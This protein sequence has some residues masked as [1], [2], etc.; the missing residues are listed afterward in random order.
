MA[1]SNQPG[2]S[3]PNASLAAR[4]RQRFGSD[5]DPRVEL[6]PD[7]NTEK[8]DER[9]SASVVNRLETRGP[10]ATR[11]R[12][13]GE[14]ARGGMG[15]IIEVFDE[16]LRRRLAM[17]VILPRGRD[18]ASAGTEDK[19]V[20]PVLLARFL[21]EAQVTGQLDHPG[22]VPV[23]ELGLD[24]QG[25]VFFTMR[26]VHGRDLEAIFDLA[27]QGRE[28]WSTTRALGVLQKVCEAMAYAHEKGVVHRDLKPANVM[29]G[30]FGEVYVMDWGLARVR[31]HVDRHD[32]RPRAT[33]GEA[34]AT[35]RP[36]EASNFVET[37]RHAASKG[38][39]DE[40]LYTMDGDI[41][42]TP[43]YMAPEQARGELDKLDE[44]TDVYAVGA[45]LYRLLAGTAPYMARGEKV[46][47]LEIWKRVMAGPPAALAT[48][49]PDAPHE[50]AAICNKAMT[51]DPAQRYPD[52]LALSADL[53]AFLEGRVVRAF[54]TGAWAE[55]RKWLGR[56]RPLAAALAAGVVALIGGLVVSLV[57]ADRARSN[58]VLA[59][60]RRVESDA[61]AAV[62]REQ[63]ALA[64]ARREQADASAAA[65]L[66]QARIAAEANA[67]LNDDLLAAIAPE[68]QG[69]D[70]TVREVLDQASLRLTGR[71]ADEPAVESA[72]RMTIGTSYFRLGEFERAREHAERAL[73][74]RRAN[75]GPRSELTLQSMRL[76]AAVWSV[77]GRMP[78][79]VDLYR[80]ALE[81]ARGI[82]GDEHRGT[83]ATMND[84]ALAL[85][86]GRRIGEARVLYEA[87]LPVQERV[88]G[89]DHEDTLATANN[90]ALMEHKLGDSSAAAKRLRHV[91][92]R[93]L[94]L[95]GAEYPAVWEAQ[96]NLST[97][98]SDLGQFAESETLA[99]GA[100]DG[101]RARLGE[102]HPRVGKAR[103]NLGV[104]VNR[105]GRTLEAERLF[106]EALE[107]TR[108]SF[109]ED[110]ADTL[111]AQHNLASSITSPKRTQE[112][113]A[114]HDKVLAGRRRMLGDEHPDTLESLNSVAMAHMRLGELAEAEKL[115]RELIELD[116]KALGADHP[117]TIIA[118]ENLANV[119]YSKKDYT[120]SEA[121]VREVLEARRRVLGE[122]HPDVS[123]TMFN[124]GMVLKSKG[125]KPGAL[126]VIESAL[127]RARAPASRNDPALAQC[128]QALGDLHVDAERYDEA[129]LAYREALQVQRL[130]HPDDATCAYLLH[131]TGFACFNLKD[132][133][134]A[135]GE[136]EEALALRAS[137]LGKDARDTRTS[138]V[139]RITT[140]VKLE[141]FADAEPLAHDYLERVL[142]AEGP[143][144]A[145]VARARKLL[146]EIYEGLGRIEDADK[147][148]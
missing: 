133:E 80:E 78:E 113:L 100:L 7:E 107:I 27:T 50:L 102:D 43:A 95:L 19:P 60:E 66:R 110:H 48:I 12:L 101:L 3:D 54:E 46:S 24:Q 140:L 137:R 44:R 40:G 138:L 32:V 63:S 59:E 62:A 10:I 96:G 139:M 118:T 112:V 47:A 34:S 81:L 25:Q 121:L 105:R 55:A 130:M 89:A 109:G 42:G 41:I 146:V 18:S 74:L 94:A 14:I 148:R 16:D 37:D 36:T 35:G 124:L 131:M 106:R 132:Y 84:L 20:D 68:N 119:L 88:L 1:L 82:L 58:A 33:E 147:W 108:K 116:T 13:E 141:R 143:E 22:I 65:A 77:M 134:T 111:L 127:E 144:H 136:F 56:N 2:N 103:G 15:A 117:S 11:Y 6:S 73:E 104:V 126:A 75:A 76:V 67:F 49:A 8:G 114:L 57:L 53:R 17:K 9:G 61:N 92:E 135:L 51:R 64:E 90:L 21:E 99:R 115:L 87:V 70:A 30:R 93:R 23:H 26:L 71:F 31:D 142:R 5:V 122:S 72:L 128:L 39:S 123:K 79:A 129:I 97:V 69:I 29:V 28:D 4:L 85:S 98:L 52:M 125:D 91:L 145:H 83:L 86:R 45:M 38:R 120:A